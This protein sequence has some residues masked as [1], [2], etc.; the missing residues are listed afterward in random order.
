MNVV[1]PPDKLADLRW[2]SESTAA[3][4]PSLLSVCDQA[5]SA[6]ALA[7]DQLASILETATGQQSLAQFRTCLETS[8]HHAAAA[9]RLAEK[10]SQLLDE[11]QTTMGSELAS[12]GK[13]VAS[14]LAGSGVDQIG[15]LVPQDVSRA[16]VLD[17]DAYDRLEKWHRQ[18]MQSV[19]VLG[20]IA[21]RVAHR[22]A[23]GNS[24]TPVAPARSARKSL[25]RTVKRLTVSSKRWNRL[26][27]QTA[28][29]R[30]AFVGTR[31][32]NRPSQWG[33]TRK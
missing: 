4:N 28:A 32:I 11:S 27:C 10:C 29:A 15:S 31:S 1:D 8:G 3:T 16:P 26:G 23:E 12:R 17:R 33:M 13:E 24:G 25:R 9:V 22:V 30:A 7:R 19:R 2:Q 18:L 21:D 6:E 20:Q 14:I 5:V